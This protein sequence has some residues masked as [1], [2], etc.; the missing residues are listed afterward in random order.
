MPRPQ[1]VRS[2]ANN[3]RRGWVKVVRSVSEVL[4]PAAAA[5]GNGHADQI[6]ARGLGLD[7]AKL[8]LHLGGFRILGIPSQPHHNP[9]KSI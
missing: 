2:G 3:V 4:L 6:G 1:V 5:A 8:P 7:D 9:N